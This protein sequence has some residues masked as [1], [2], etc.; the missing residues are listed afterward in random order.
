M[1]CWRTW[2]GSES[3]GT[4]LRRGSRSA[5]DWYREAL[6]RLIARGLAYPCTCSRKDLELAITAPHEA[7]DEPIYNGR[8]RSSRSERFITGVNY[9]LRIPDEERVV[10]RD[11]NLG[12]H[13][14]FFGRDFG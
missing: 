4:L 1:P 9:R 14:Y 6:D 2:S 12:E 3:R 7:D 11:G 5:L 13:A 10:V 8:C